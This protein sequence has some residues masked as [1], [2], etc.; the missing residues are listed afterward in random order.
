VGQRVQSFGSGCENFCL[1][2]TELINPQS[3]CDTSP[4]LLVGFRRRCILG[5]IAQQCLDRFKNWLNALATGT[6]SL[7]LMPSN[8]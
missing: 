8:A 6:I 1:R 4:K 7:S 3:D 5:D 2:E